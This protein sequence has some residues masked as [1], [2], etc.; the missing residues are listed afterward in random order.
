M[1]PSSAYRDYLEPAGPACGTGGVDG[2]VPQIRHAGL[3][4]GVMLFSLA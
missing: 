4:L 3:K 1:I 2:G